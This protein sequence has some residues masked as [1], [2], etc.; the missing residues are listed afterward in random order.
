MM[1][2]ETSKNEEHKENDIIAT[3]VVWL[4][5]WS[6][7]GHIIHGKSSSVTGDKNGT[8]GWTR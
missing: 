3:Y 7:K 6:S 1:K 5:K 2:K 4:M 8:S